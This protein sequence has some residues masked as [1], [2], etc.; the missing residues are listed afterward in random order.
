MAHFDNQIEQV[1]RD[2]T[3]LGRTHL[4]SRLDYLIAERAKAL[5]EEMEILERASPRDS[6]ARTVQAFPTG[7]EEFR[8]SRCNNLLRPGTRTGHVCANCWL[9]EQ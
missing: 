3:V 4:K 6:A 5:R 7:E 8:C 1:R 9:D 2:I